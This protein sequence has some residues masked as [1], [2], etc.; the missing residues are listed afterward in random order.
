MSGVVEY[1][2]KC[3]IKL[4]LP[5]TKIIELKGQHKRKQVAHGRLDR[6]FLAFPYFKSS[7]FCKLTGLPNIEN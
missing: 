1:V 2:C 7:G 4:N 3:T 5:P 6:S